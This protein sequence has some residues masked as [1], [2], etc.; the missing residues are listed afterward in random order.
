MQDRKAKKKLIYV[1]GCGRSGTTILG[2]ALGNGHGCLDLGEVIDFLKRRGVPNSYGPETK[3]G[4]FWGEVTNCIVDQ[5]KDIFD[6]RSVDQLTRLE[7]HNNFPLAFFGLNKRSALLDYSDYTNSLHGCISKNSEDIS[8]YI[9]SSKYPGRA[10]L[11]YSLLR[12]FDVSI[13]HIVRHP[14][15]VVA[16]F[17]DKRK[18]DEQGY[19]GY[20]SANFYYFVINLFCSAV[21]F[22]VCSRKYLKIRYEDLL[23]APHETLG[24]IASQFE[25]DLQRV[26]D[27][28]D[29]NEPLKK[30]FIFN[31]NRMSMGKDTELR[32]KKSRKLPFDRT[33]KNAV[34]LLINRMWY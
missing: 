23:E 19:K 33:I 5:E 20:I 12:D 29:Q 31:G 32:L 13:L 4:Q 1:M 8:V 28:I 24:K 17:G 30:G 14:V 25:I 27:L 22:R 7:R 21:R 2:V 26:G 18:R 11:S 34:V 9:D 6:E 3:T 16:S 10:F 15:K